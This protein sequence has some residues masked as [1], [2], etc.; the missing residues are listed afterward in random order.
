M[1]RIMLAA[2]AAAN[3]GSSEE[4]QPDQQQHHHHQQAQWRQQ[5]QHHHHQQQ[6]AHSLQ[7]SSSALIRWCMPGLPRYCWTTAKREKTQVKGSGQHDGA[8]QGCRGIAG[9]LRSGS[10]D[11]RGHPAHFKLRCTQRTWRQHGGRACA[12]HVTLFRKNQRSC[13]LHTRSCCCSLHSTGLHAGNP[14][15]SDRLASR[16][17]VWTLT[18]LLGRH[19]LRGQRQHHHGAGCIA[20]VRSHVNLRRRRGV[21][22]RAHQQQATRRTAQRMCWRH[23][24]GAGGTLGC[25][26]GNTGVLFTRRSAANAFKQTNSHLPAAPSSPPLTACLRGWVLAPR[27]PPAP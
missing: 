18:G 23:H 11:G 25:S 17:E 1:R 19:E 4:Q 8:C 15:G 27:P 6:Q 12:V 7:R 24:G 20:G 16:L 13:F 22:Q 9:Q 14:T 21:A 3:D 26:P 2:A 10:M 5:Q